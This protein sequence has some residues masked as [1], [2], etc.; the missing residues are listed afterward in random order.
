MRTLLVPLSLGLAIAVVSASARAQ[1]SDAERAAAR[2]LFKQGDELQHQG[3]LAP[4]LEK[5]QRAQQVFPA[6]T[7]LLRIAE[8][9]AGLGK[10]VEATETYR[11]LVR[12][13]LP[14]GSPSAFQGAV[15]QANAELPQVEPRV[16]RVTI[17]V[18][19]QG[20]AG[21]ALQ[22]DGQNAPA[23]LIGTP[24]PLDPGPHAIV[25]SGQGFGALEQRVVLQEREAK[26]ISFALRPLP[27]G[28]VPAPPPPQPYVGAAPPPGY[29][30]QP[31]VVYAAPPPPEQQLPPRPPERKSNMGVL[32][33]LHFGDEFPAGNLPGAVGLTNVSGPGFAYGLDGGF[34]FARVWYVGATFEHAELD[35]NSDK[36]STSLLGAMISLI[37]NPDRVSFYGSVGAAARWYQAT[38]D[39]VQTPTLSGGELTLGLGIWIPIGSS[40]RLLPEMTASIGSFSNNNNAQTDTNGAQETQEFY[41]L[42]VGGFYNLDL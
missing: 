10:I 14:P 24:I 13:P 19:P 25:V 34:R 12:T 30:P 42:G 18:M 8:C 6:P 9:Q 22:I 20:V 5:F 15:D 2:E 37:T 16:P 26:T 17:Q 32:F 36:S 31:I 21:Q 11:S 41:M 4:A 23:A 40:V 28:A 7:N 39:G 29:G 27:P 35:K 33:G 38:I 3:Q 1:V